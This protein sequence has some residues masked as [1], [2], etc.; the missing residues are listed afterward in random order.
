MHDDRVWNLSFE[1]RLKV[2]TSDVI[3]LGA[4]LF[5]TYSNFIYQNQCH[6]YEMEL[7]IFIFHWI[8]Y[9]IILSINIIWTSKLKQLNFYKLDEI[10]AFGI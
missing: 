6:E 9:T 10:D 1:F 4:Q 2:N 5:V 7:A 3:T 8:Y